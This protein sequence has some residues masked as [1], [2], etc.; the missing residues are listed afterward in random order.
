LEYLINECNLLVKLEPFEHLN[1]YNF[2]TGQ[3][4]IIKSKNL[5]TDFS[6]TSI[7]KMGNMVLVH[8]ERYLY[9]N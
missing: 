5:A 4:N 3:W 8:G 6:Y 7:Y 9:S 1:K 2:I